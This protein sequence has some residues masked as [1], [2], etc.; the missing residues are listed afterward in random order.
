MSC[1]LMIFGRA[2]SIRDSTGTNETLTTVKGDVALI[3]RHRNGY[4]LTVTLTEL[5]RP[6]GINILPGGPCPGASGVASPGSRSK[7]H[8]R[9]RQS[10]I[11]NS[12][13]SS[14][15]LCCAVSPEH[16]HGVGRPP[17][18]P[19]ENTA[20][21]PSSRKISKSTQDDHTSSDNGLV[22]FRVMVFFIFSTL[23]VVTDRL[24][25]APDNW[26]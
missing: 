3:T 14:L 22:A 2:N 18:E 9:P 19:R 24:R 15:T 10:R 20:N 12:I 5:H 17:C 26:I 8:N 4:I 23:D 16:Q 7:K 13:R 25:S 21:P 1:L 6:A 11:R